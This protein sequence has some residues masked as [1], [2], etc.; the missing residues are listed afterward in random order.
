M[1]IDINNLIKTYS[2][3]NVVSI[4]SFRVDDGDFLG[5]VGNNGAGKTTL[6]RMIVDLVKAD[7]GEV[8]LSY[9][10]GEGKTVTVNPARSEDW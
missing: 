8:A 6:F 7:E 9:I 10:N 4:D 2:K 5:L 1:R 3:K